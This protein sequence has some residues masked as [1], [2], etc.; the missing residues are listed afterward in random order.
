MVKKIAMLAFVGVVATAGL[1]AKS[2]KTSQTELIEA[3]QALE[4]V[5][6]ADEQ[7][8]KTMPTFKDLLIGKLI[9]YM[10]L[11]GININQDVYQ[12]GALNIVKGRRN[13]DELGEKAK[14]EEKGIALSPIGIFN[15]T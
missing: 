12:R 2:N 1:H 8:L 7:V 3:Q 6:F 4:E 14:K 9:P 5:L 13:G 10:V 15:Q 11:K